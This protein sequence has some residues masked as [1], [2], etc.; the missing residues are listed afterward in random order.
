MLVTIQ[1]KKVETTAE[2]KFSCFYF[3]SQYMYMICHIILTLW[4]WKTFMPTY[5]VLTLKI[6]LTFYLFADLFI[7]NPIH[8]YAPGAS[9]TLYVNG[10]TSNGGH[11]YCTYCTYLLLH[12]LICMLQ[13]PTRLYLQN[14]TSK[15]KKNIL[16]T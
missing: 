10:V 13:C 1:F 11:T 5:L 6:L 3:T 8:F 7:M 15:E 14:T 16:R 2:N 4:K 9:Q 12:A